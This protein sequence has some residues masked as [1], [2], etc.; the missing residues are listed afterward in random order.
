M[1]KQIEWQK[2][3]RE[4]V[5]Q[6]DELMSAMGNIRT[7]KNRKIDSKP[8]VVSYTYGDVIVKIGNKFYDALVNIENRK[9]GS[10]IVYDISNI[11]ET[12]PQRTNYLLSG[13]MFITLI[14]HKAHQMSR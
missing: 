8:S 12:S 10:S 6:L 9:N 4:A 14:Y 11:K 1:V 7:E 3:Q 13:G 2:L 5:H